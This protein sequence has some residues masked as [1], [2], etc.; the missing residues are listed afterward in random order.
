M[1]AEVMCVTVLQYV[2][3]VFL[4]EQNKNKKTGHCSSV[5]NFACKKFSEWSITGSFVLSPSP[6]ALRKH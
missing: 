4:L 1:V 3:P 5:L 2:P 6:L